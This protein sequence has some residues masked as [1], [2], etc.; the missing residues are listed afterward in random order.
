MDVWDELRAECARA[1]LYRTRAEAGRD[2]RE[3]I[4]AV[5]R[6]ALREANIELMAVEVAATEQ[7]ETAG[8]WLVRSL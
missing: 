7:E 1:V 2:D 4:T 5:V 8:A 6:G 3:R